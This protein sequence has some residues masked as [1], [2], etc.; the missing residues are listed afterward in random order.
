MDAKITTSVRPPYQGRHRP[1]RDAK[2]TAESRAVLERLTYQ[3]RHRPQA[4]MIA[5]P[6][7]TIAPELERYY[8]LQTQ[9]RL[10]KEG[11]SIDDAAALAEID[12]TDARLAQAVTR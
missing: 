6:A 8:Y 4:V 10:L 12:A 3:G 1:P 11:R 9:T 2:T 5:P 7:F